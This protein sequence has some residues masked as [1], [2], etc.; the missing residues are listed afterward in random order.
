APF[1]S[2]IRSHAGSSRL[3]LA[4]YSFGGVIA[5][6]A[7]RQLREQGLDVQDV[8][9]FDTWSA[10]AKELA[11]RN[12]WPDMMIAFE[13]LRAARPAGSLAARLHIAWTLLQAA[14]HA[15]MRRLV[16][17][18]KLRS[19]RAVDASNLTHV[20]DEDGIP[21]GWSLLSTMYTHARRTWGL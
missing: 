14:L 6:D 20:H 16:K 11:W 18:R 8:I 19:R 21:L 5:F 3:A 1:V 7:A 15:D 4:G 13:A 12:L 10:P 9:L 17:K 2:A